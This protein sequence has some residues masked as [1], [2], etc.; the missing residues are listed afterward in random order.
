MS[1]ATGEAADAHP[2]PLHD[3]HRVAAAHRLLA[4]VSVGAYDRL[5]RLAARLTTAPAAVVCLLTDEEIVL[6]SFGLPAAVSSGPLPLAG[7]P[8]AVTARLGSP[9]VVWDAATD[10]RLA[11]LPAV[12]D[13]DVVAYLGVPLRALSGHVVGVLAVFDGS[14]RRWSDDDVAALEQLAASVVAELELSTANAALGRS[15]A[16]LD[17]A[18]EASEV[19]IWEV[20]LA[21]SHIDWDARCAAIFG[22]DDVVRHP[23]ERL[24]A[25]H[26]HP[27]DQAMAQEAMQSAIDARAQYTVEVRV[28]R[29]DGGV[30]WTVSR[31][32]VFAD[33]DGRP[34]RILGTV[35]DVTGSKEQAEARLAATRRA[36]TIFEVAAEMANATGIDQLADMALRGAQVLGAE[37]GGISVFDPSDGALRLHLG[38]RLSDAARTERDILVPPQGLEIAQDDSL[39]PQHVARH[40]EPI[41]LDTAEESAARFPRMAEMT[42]VY[43]V[44][45]LAA[46][47]LRIEERLLGSFVATWAEDHGFLKEDVG[48]LEALAAQITLT[49]S[50]LHADA[51]RTAAVAAMTQ[52]NQRL[53]LLADAGRLLSNTLDISEQLDRLASLVIPALGDWC[54]IVATDDHGHMREAAAAHRDPARQG[55]VATYL[56]LMLETITDESAPRIV[57]RT[58]QPLIIPDLSPERI[59]RSLFDPEARAVLHSLDPASVAAVP[60]VARGETLGVLCL[61]NGAGRGPHTASDIETALEIGRRAGLA[62]DQ[63]RLYGQKRELADALQRSML[64]APPEPDHSEIAVRYVPAAEG[65]EIGG[66]WYDAFLQEDGATVLAIG[67]VAGHDTRA[68]AAMGQVRGLLRGIGYSSGGTPAEI[69]AELDRAVQGLALDT[70]ATALVGRLEQSDEGL[71]AGRTWFRWSS[72]GHLAPVLIDADGNVTLLD[73]VPAD[74]LLGVAPDVPREDRVVCLDRDAIVLLYTDGLVERR[75]RDVD[76]GTEELLA[77]LREHARLP[78]EELCDVVLERLFLPDAEDD[79]AILAVRLHPQDALRPTEAGPQDVPPGIAPSPPVHPGAPPES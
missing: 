64:T 14:V 5:A 77:V 31:G 42:E 10:E 70:M 40:G 33:A 36:A 69:L 24:F 66:D 67:D 72:A 61:L 27:D 18:L 41:L 56:G 8:C 51:E 79:V 73:D 71:R 55:D 30:R 4:D 15:L 78:L 19:G 29:C 38:R 2:D 26:V 35:I 54:W 52:A 68:A 57:Y 43:G 76:T 11:D 53:Q 3:L 48:L 60:L 46:L 1:E 12:A 6:G 34:T 37:S 25:E 23:L 62:V 20:D 28:V 47:P 21:R 9:L 13:G 45:A 65:A 49:V 17:V 59:A 16:R 58:G 74:L 7:S 32:R 39:P 22:Y 44:R 50:R 63:A 75:D